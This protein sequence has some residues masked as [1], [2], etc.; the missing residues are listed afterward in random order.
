MLCAHSHSI[1][2]TKTP[3]THL[4]NRA[5]ENLLVEIHKYFQNPRLGQYDFYVADLFA[6]STIISKQE[7]AQP[8]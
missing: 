1:K 6:L 3:Y 2:A 8:L 7:R 4:T 5:M